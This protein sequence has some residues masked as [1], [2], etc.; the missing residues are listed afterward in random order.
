LVALLERAERL[1]RVRAEIRNFADSR[2][3]KTMEIGQRTVMIPISAAW[4][5]F[6]VEAPADVLLKQIEVFTAAQLP[7][8]SA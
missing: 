5:V 2:M 7:R 3:D 8:D 6:P 4:V 1:D